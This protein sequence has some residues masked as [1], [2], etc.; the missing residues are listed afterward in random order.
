MISLRSVGFASSRK[1]DRIEHHQAREQSVARHSVQRHR[2]QRRAVGVPQRNPPHGRARRG[3]SVP[4][5][6]CRLARAED[7]RERCGFQP[8]VHLAD[9]ISWSR[10]RQNLRFGGSVTRH[11]SG[12]TGSEPGQAILG[13]FTFLNTTTRSFNEL[14]LADVQQYSQ[15]VN[16]GVSSYELKQWMSVAFVQDS[17]RVNDD[18]TLD[19]GFRYD[20]QTLTDATQ[21]FAPRVGFDWHPNG[22][23]RPAVRGG[24][25][26]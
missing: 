17:I 14:T 21:N 16:Y 22:A 13:T 20:R 1:P 18:L 9:T 2:A 6:S 19:A 4:A 24:Y 10:G 12:G 23:A 5:R 26:M 11:T 3:G 25:A 8:A 15:P 7:D